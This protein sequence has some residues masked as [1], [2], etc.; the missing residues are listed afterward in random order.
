MKAENLAKILTN[1]I[2]FSVQETHTA[3]WR[4]MRP[5]LVYT[6]QGQGAVTSQVER[7]Q[8]VDWKPFQRPWQNF[9]CEITRI[10]AKMESDGNCHISLDTLWRLIPWLGRLWWMKENNSVSHWTRLLFTGGA[11]YQW[12]KLTPVPL[13]FIY[14]ETAKPPSHP[15]SIRENCG[16]S[17]ARREPNLGRG[18]GW[19]H[20]KG[21]EMKCKFE[22]HLYI[23]DN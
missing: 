3:A 23:S 10:L 11:G 15:Y 14:N 22:Y 21:L 2:L 20:L 17:K 16:L 9:S 4:K 7:K 8:K 13:E 1:D 19:H 6:Q 18:E 12:G 5:G